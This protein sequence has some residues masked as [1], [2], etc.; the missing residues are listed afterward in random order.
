[1]KIINIFS[2]QFFSHFRY[3]NVGGTILVNGRERD[4]RRFRKMACYIMQNDHLHAHLTVRESMSVSANLKLG[5]KMKLSEKEEIVSIV[6]NFVQ[7]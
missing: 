2:N 1:M 3:S 4:L 6:I 5:N 7:I